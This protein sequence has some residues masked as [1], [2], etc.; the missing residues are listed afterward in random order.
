VPGGRPT[1]GR[2]AGHLDPRDD[3][4]PRPSRPVDAAVERPVRR[5]HRHLG[6]DGVSRCR[7]A[8]PAAPDSRCPLARRAVCQ[9]A[10]RRDD[11]VDGHRQRLAQVASRG[12]GRLQLARR[13]GSQTAG[14]FRRA[15]RLPAECRPADRSQDRPSRLARHSG[16]REGDP[17][18]RELLAGEEPSRIPR[19]D[20]TG[21]R[22]LAPDLDRRSVARASRAR[23]GSCRGRRAR[24]ARDAARCAA[25][26]RGGRRDGRVRRARAAVDRRGDAARAARGDEPRPPVDR[27]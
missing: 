1:P 8:R 4:G 23:R 24:R 5:R 19:G 14:R 3:G 25:P 17:P 2:V 16:R 7:P 13:L 9:R 10:G 18:R 15:G 22:R 21:R 20:G 26:R 12:C 11:P 6:A 27:V